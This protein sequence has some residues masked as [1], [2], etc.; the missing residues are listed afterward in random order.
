LEITG[1]IPNPSFNDL[2]KI[3][4]VNTVKSDIRRGNLVKIGSGYPLNLQPESY[5][6]EWQNRFCEGLHYETFYRNQEQEQKDKYVKK[7]FQ[8]H[9]NAD[10]SLFEQLL[11]APEEG[12][13]VYISEFREKGFNLVKSIKFAK[14]KAVW[15]TIIEIAKKKNIKAAHKM[16]L[17]IEYSNKYRSYQ[18]FCSRYKVLTKEKNI[19]VLPVRIGKESPNKKLTPFHINLM[20]GYAAHPKKYTFNMIAELINY[21]AI[22]Q[23]LVEQSEVVALYEALATLAPVTAPE[24]G[25]LAHLLATTPAQQPALQH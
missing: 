22:K 7:I 20:E 9:L 12:F 10:Y 15:L 17:E 14:D 11:N 5:I 8:T 1:Y 23:G 16:Y 6:T 18:N 21:E 24:A 25:T 19:N 13:N 3:K 4:S 2:A